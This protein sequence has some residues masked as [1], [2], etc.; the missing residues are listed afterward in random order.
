MLS[1]C[2]FLQA[3]EARPGVAEDTEVVV[4][5]P[6]TLAQVKAPVEKPS[7]ECLLSASAPFVASRTCASTATR[8]VYC[9]AACFRNVSKSAQE[10]HT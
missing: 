8:S 4:L 5:D 1:Y 2:C 7:R 6:L 3:E 10:F 9:V